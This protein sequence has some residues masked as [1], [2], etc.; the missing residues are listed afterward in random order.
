MGKGIAGSSKICFK[1]GEQGLVFDTKTRRCR[2]PKKLG[3]P[4]K[5]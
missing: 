5:H 2:M 1:K 3:R 4:K